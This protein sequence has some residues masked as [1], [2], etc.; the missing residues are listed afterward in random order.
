MIIDARGLPC[1]QPIMATKKALD[2]LTETTNIDIYLEDEIAKCNVE[3]Y[4]GE[5][6]I[7]CAH[8]VD[9]NTYILSFT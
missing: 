4:L 3:A 9:N 1:P 7:S 5:M 8:K 2:A 6:G